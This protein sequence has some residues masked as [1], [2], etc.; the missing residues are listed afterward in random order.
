MLNRILLVVIGS[1][2]AFAA[3]FLAVRHSVIDQTPK[4]VMTMI[5]ARIAKLAGDVN[6]CRHNRNYG[7]RAGSV[8]RAN[9]DSIVTS[10]AYD[11]SGGPVYLT[12]AVWP[13]YWSLSVYQHNTDNIFVIN[14]RQLE[15]DEFQ[16]VI[17]GQGQPVQKRPDRIVVESPSMTGI[18]LIRR[19]AP[20]PEDMAGA[21]ENQDAM[22]CGPLDAIQRGEDRD[23]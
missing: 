2:L 22:A 5:E 12:G 14:D 15:T 19:F 6:T 9:P 18:V 8:A 1:G 13:R 16:I 21:R 20:R 10:M 3:A 23:G 7:P 4:T 17:A 11:L